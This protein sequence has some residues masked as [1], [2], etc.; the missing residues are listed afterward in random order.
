MEEC[1]IHTGRKDP[2]QPVDYAVEYGEFQYQAG[3]W[4][5]PQRVVFK[6]EKPYEQMP[7][8]GIAPFSGG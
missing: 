6:V 5:Y 3:S 1:E 8:R 2:L 7:D 4:V